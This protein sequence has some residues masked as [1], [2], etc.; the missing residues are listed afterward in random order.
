MVGEGHRRI[1]NSFFGKDCRSFAAPY[2][3]NDAGGHEYEANNA[4]QRDRPPVDHRR[5]RA[6]VL[7]CGNGPARMRPADCLERLKGVSAVVTG[8]K[9]KM[10]GGQRVHGD[11]PRKKMFGRRG[12]GTGWN[13]GD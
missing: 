8:P 2:G 7:S 12:I 6:V 1:I 13:T 4:G 11:L 3:Q 5:V 9:A 10:S